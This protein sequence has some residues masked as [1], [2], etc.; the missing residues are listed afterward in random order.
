M[1][2]AR[3][4]SVHYF[5]RW[6]LLAWM[7]FGLSLLLAAGACRRAEPVAETATAS[8]AGQGTLAGTLRGPDGTTPIWGRTVQAVNVQTGERR[9]VVTSNTGV[10]TFELPAGRYRLEPSLRPGEVVVRQ[11]GVIDLTRGH[12]DAPVHILLAASRA[13]HPHGPAYRTNNGLGS[14]IA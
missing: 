4:A 9:E 2:H 13:A 5:P 14:P 8:P 10:F 12:V 11:P 1:R 3:A 7:L 6:V